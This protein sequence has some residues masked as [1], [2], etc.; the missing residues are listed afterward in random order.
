MPNTVDEIQEKMN[1]C[2]TE[3]RDKENAVCNLRN[4]LKQLKKD[5]E[6]AIFNMVLDYIEIGDEIE[7]TNG[8]ARGGLCRG[9]KVQVIKKNK[10]SVSVK[11]LYRERNWYSDKIGDTKRIVSGIFGEYVY[12]HTDHIKTMIERDQTL[13]ALLGEDSWARDI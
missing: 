13:K 6:F 11:Y 1:E 12:N 3:I 10:K 4:N 7:F 2:Y 5:K 8:W 9:D